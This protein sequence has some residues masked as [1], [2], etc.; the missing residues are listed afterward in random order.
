M[1]TSFSEVTTSST[2]SSTTS[3]SSASD[4]D[5]LVATVLSAA[6]GG[7]ISTLDAVTGALAEPKLTSSGG[8][9][10]GLLH[11]AW[12]EQ[13]YRYADT[14]FRI[15]NSS[16]YVA[17]HVSPAVGSCFPSSFWVLLCSLN[18]KTPFRKPPHVSKCR[19]PSL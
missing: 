9:F 13:M 15:L 18:S 5:E 14:F 7:E 12:L 16:T 17:A 1:A 11:A 2:S 6:Y 19:P 4:S 8:F 10:G 3:S